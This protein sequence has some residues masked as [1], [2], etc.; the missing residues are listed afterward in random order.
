V[1]G[2]GYHRPSL[3]R[4]VARMSAGGSL[5]DMIAPRTVA[6]LFAA[7]MSASSAK[8]TIRRRPLCR[9]SGRRADLTTSQRIS[10]VACLQHPGQRTFSAPGRPSGGAKT[11][12]TRRSPRATLKQDSTYLRRRGATR[13]AEGTGY[14]PNGLGLSLV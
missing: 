9:D 4:G 5:V 13:I 12:A 11:M 3:S 7:D 6:V 8:P 1:G 2:R 10:A 14:R